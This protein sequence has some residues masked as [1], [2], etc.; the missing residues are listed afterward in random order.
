MSAPPRDTSS[1][2]IRALTPADTPA[3]RALRRKILST[4]DARYFSDS[5][6]REHQLTESQ[7]VEWCTERPEH[8]VL[9][10]FAGAELIGVL[11]ITRQGG[12]ESPV[13]E[14]EAAWLDSRYRG[15]G[16]GKRAYARARQWTQE[17]GYK[18]V[19]G[20]IR[21]VY[22]PALD[23]C[24]NQGFVYAYTIRSERWADGSTADTHAFL[25]DLV[26]QESSGNAL[27]LF[28]RFAEALPFISQGLH[29][30][31]SPN[32]DEWLASPLW[33]MSR[34]SS[35]GLDTARV[36]NRLRH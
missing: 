29:A 30:P 1:I 26:P 36:K 34:S 10:T 9:G 35:G 17:Q 31:P 14:W 24:R 23:I 3:Y 15:A 21:A 33:P 2:T 28:A 27:C 5:Y 13:V 18:Y 25:L 16:I 7:W 19:V 12:R 4:S 11:M 32:D 8:C 20:F 6:T 22:T